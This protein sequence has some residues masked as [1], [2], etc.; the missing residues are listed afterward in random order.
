MAIKTS[1]HPKKGSL[2]NISIKPLE[3]S[4]YQT[5]IEVGMLAYRQHYLHLWEDQNPEPYIK[6]S[7][8]LE[9]LRNEALNSNTKL[10][11]IYKDALPIGILKINLDHGLDHHPS[12]EVLLLDKIY[13]MKA[14]SG[15]GVGKKVLEFVETLA[16]SSNKKIITLETMKKGPALGFYQQNGFEALKEIR[17]GF[18]TIKEDQRAMYVMFKKLR[19]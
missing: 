6:I 11:L 16:R 14:Y 8:T 15:Q 3:V 12:K 9:V 10:F 4:L 1:R 18:A 7:F 2:S 13:I 17:L 5:Y 19:P